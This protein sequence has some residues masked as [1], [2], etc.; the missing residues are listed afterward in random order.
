MTVHHIPLELNSDF[1]GVNMPATLELETDERPT[2]AGPDAQ[3]EEYVVGYTLI[4]Q[5]LPLSPEKLAALLRE[6][7]DTANEIVSGVPA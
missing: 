5:P 4:V 3:Y 2:S 7:L 6:Y 1:Y